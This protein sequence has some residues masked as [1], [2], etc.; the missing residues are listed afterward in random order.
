MMMKYND[1]Y[2]DLVENFLNYMNFELG[3]WEVPNKV[4]LVFFDD[5]DKEFSKKSMIMLEELK[6]NRKDI[7]EVTKTTSKQSPWRV[8]TPVLF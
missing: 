6:T 5:G 7:L 4:N 3:K 2:L 1:K 8:S